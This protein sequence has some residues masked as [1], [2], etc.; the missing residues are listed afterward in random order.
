MH[1]S[2]LSK[3]MP[4]SGQTDGH[5]H[6]KSPFFDDYKILSE[7]KSHTYWLY[8]SDFNLG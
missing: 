8:S 5:L 1:K 3:I 6:Y 4:V 7:I 2:A